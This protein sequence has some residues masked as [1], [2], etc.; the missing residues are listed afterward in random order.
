MNWTFKIAW[1]AL[2]ESVSAVMQ[3]YLQ[4]MVM[5]S[6]EVCSIAKYAFGMWGTPIEL[7]CPLFFVGVGLLCLF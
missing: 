4:E 5:K 1:L 2:H 3:F 6:S 7:T